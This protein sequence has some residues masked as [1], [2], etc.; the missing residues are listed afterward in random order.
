MLFV[1]RVF[2]IVTMWA[3]VFL[4]H[5]SAQ[6]LFQPQEEVPKI[7]VKK[8]FDKIDFAY[9]ASAGYLAA[10]TGLDVTTTVG[11]LDRPQWHT[12]RTTRS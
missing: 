12:G 2:L 3:A 5:L 6:T 4:P 9:W 1:V 11:G 10:A 8:K 7:P